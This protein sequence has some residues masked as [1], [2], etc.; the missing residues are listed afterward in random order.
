MYRLVS[1]RYSA[2]RPADQ[3][4]RAA[5]T[6]ESAGQTKAEID[7]EGAATALGS[8]FTPGLSS[9]SEPHESSISIL[10]VF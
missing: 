5:V 6:A 3:T 1:D 8:G 7:G 2:Y 4:A 9:R 10:V